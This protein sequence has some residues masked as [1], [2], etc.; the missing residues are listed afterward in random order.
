MVVLAVC[1]PVILAYKM[2]AYV[3]Q[4]QLTAAISAGI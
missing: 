4:W 1:K 3:L 2:L